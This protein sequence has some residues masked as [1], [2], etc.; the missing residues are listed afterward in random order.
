MKIRL[1]NVR[2][3]FPNIFEPQVSEDGKSSYGAALLFAPDHP[4]VKDI[5]AAIASVAADKWGAKADAMLKQ[6]KA[7]DKTALHNGDT[8]AQYAGYEG[9]LFVNARNPVRPTAVDTDK[10][11]LQQS[12]GRLYAGCYV[13]AVLEFWAQ[14]N[15]FGKRINAT[16]M[17]VQFYRDGDAFS[18]GGAASDDEFDDVS[19]GA[20][21]GDFV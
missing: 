17:G 14:D 18:G 1:N 20:E 10:T 19:A 21:S 7:A 16:L 3:A 9:N 11:P 2:L 12:D 8:K 15:K 5:H 13:N 6:I 4:Q